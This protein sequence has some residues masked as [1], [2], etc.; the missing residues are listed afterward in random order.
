MYYVSKKIDGR[1]KGKRTK[2]QRA[3]NPGGKQPENR[4]RGCG[5]RCCHDTQNDNPSD[6][7]SKSR[8]VRYDFFYLLL[9]HLYYLGCFDNDYHSHFLHPILSHLLGRYRSFHAKDLDTIP[10]RFSAYHLT[11]KRWQL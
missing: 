9:V 2:E 5:Y 3:R 4:S 10:R 11:Q 8:R 1:A 6:Y 7:G